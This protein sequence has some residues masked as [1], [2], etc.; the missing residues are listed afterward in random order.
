[1][2]DHEIQEHITSL[3]DRLRHLERARDLH[4][5]YNRW[6]AAEISA[7]AWIVESYVGCDFP[8]FVRVAELEAKERAARKGWQ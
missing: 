6:R 5:G 8:E 7:L 3:V 2:S 1:M 4:G